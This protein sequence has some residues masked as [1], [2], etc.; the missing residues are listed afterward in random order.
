MHKAQKLAVSALALIALAA[1]ALRGDQNNDDNRGNRRIALVD[2]CDPDD[3]AWLP[4]GCLQK[5][6]DV[7]LAEFN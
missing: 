1:P 3:P 5:D 6:G 4:I 2:D 7:T